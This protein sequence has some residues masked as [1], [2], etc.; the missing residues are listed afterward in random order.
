MTIIIFFACTKTIF[1]INQESYF[2]YTVFSE[3]YNFTMQKMIFP[4]IFLAAG[5]S[6]AEIPNAMKRAVALFNHRP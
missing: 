4:P 3:E 1:T 2:F 6:G 5:V